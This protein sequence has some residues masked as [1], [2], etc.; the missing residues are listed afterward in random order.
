M[1]SSIAIA[2]DAVQSASDRTDDATVREQLRSVDEAL[3]DLSGDETLPDETEEGARLEEL[4][5]ELVKLGNH[6]DGAVHEQLEV[7]RD[8]LD[9]YRREHAPDWES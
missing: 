8:S 1:V 3:E 2:R 5:A 6:T 4:E 7:A 9:R